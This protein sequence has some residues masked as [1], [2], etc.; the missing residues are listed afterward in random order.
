[1]QCFMKHAQD[2]IDLDISEEDLIQ[3]KFNRLQEE[4]QTTYTP[5]N[6]RK[7][8]RSMHLLE[9]SSSSSEKKM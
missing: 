1:M 6:F 3:S 4:I 9:S 2:K 7:H 5:D 8:S